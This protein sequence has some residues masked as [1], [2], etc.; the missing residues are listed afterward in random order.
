MKK[1]KPVLYSLSSELVLPAKKTSCS[2]E[3]VAWIPTVYSLTW[4]E[5]RSVGCRGYSLPDWSSTS[6][7]YLGGFWVRAV[8]LKGCDK[9]TGYGIKFSI[10]EL[11]R[12]LGWRPGSA[13]Q[14]VKRFRTVGMRGQELSSNLTL[15]KINLVTRT[16]FWNNSDRQYTTKPS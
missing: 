15:R 14:L 9:N 5:A 4:R 12:A 10:S 11:P 6:W 3:G 7:R 8:D 16:V 1:K 2:V 13:E